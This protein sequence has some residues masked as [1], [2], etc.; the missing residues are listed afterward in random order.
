MVDA[1]RDW[2]VLD[3]T[4]EWHERWRHKNLDSVDMNP[5]ERARS[6]QAENMRKPSDIP[7]FDP[8]PEFV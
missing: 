6:K 3:E 8:N 2:T 7:D 5:R 4:T 1:E